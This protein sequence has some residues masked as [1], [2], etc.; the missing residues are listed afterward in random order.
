MS[1]LSQ[2]QAGFTE[3]LRLLGCVRTNEVEVH[4]LFRE[5][6]ISGSEWFRP[7]HDVLDYVRSH[8]IPTPSGTGTNLEVI[9][10]GR[11]SKRLYAEIVA[12]QDRLAKL[13]GFQSG[14]IKVF[15][16]LLELGL[17][18]SRKRR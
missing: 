3:R 16:M 6:R 9:M 14:T 1:R 13:S 15:R 17:K 11:I 18:E 5:H 4:R 2:L 10:S 8:S 7:H 12:E